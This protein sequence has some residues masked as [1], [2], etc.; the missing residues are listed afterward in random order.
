MGRAVTLNV[1]SSALRV[2]PRSSI[3]T[4]NTISISFKDVMEITFLKAMAEM[5]GFTPE[6]A[7]I[8]YMAGVE[9]TI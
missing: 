2:A 3:S 1:V 8:L 9:T 4:I 6:L 7:M 5:T